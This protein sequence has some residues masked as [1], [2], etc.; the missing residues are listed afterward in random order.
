MAGTETA[1]RRVGAAGVAAWGRGCRRPDIRFGEAVTGDRVVA[2]AS[3]PSDTGARSAVSVRGKAELPLTAVPIGLTEKRAA[4]T[5][6]LGDHLKPRDVGVAA[7][8]AEHRELATGASA[9]ARP[10]SGGARQLG[11]GRADEPAE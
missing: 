2:A 11:A 5:T 6:A 7:G 10:V 1:A 4:A 8:A 9:A 3:S